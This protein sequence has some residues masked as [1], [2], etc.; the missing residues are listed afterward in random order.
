MHSL[1]V[2]CETNVLSLI[3]QRLDNYYQIKTKRY[4]TLQ[5]YRI[6][7]APNP[8]GTK[9]GL[10]NFGK[11]GMQGVFEVRAPS[12]QAQRR[13][14]GTRLQAGARNLG[15]ILVRVTRH[16]C[17]LDGHELSCKSCIAR[18]FVHKLLLSYTKA[19]KPLVRSRKKIKSFGVWIFI[20]WHAISSFFCRRLMSGGQIS[21]NNEDFF[22]H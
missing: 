14:L 22:F 12:A 11:K 21:S 1:V 15:C 2:L 17:F 6:Q 8:A 13:A 20:F 19:C 5:C 18:N 10:R 7:P 16:V 4:S 3:S 9:R